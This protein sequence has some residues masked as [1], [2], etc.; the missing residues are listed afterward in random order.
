MSSEATFIP[1]LVNFVGK[2]QIHALFLQGHHEA[3]EKHK[4]KVHLHF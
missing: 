2:T 4:C 3:H 1:Q